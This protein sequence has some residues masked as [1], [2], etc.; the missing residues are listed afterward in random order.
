MGT[1]RTGAGEAR[2][3]NGAISELPRQQPI[4]DNLEAI[5]ARSAR[6]ER[7]LALLAAI[8]PEVEAEIAGQPG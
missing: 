5:A 3:S 6:I 1:T 7:M 2:V 8:R 4:R